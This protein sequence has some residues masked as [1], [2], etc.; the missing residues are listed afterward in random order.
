MPPTDFKGLIYLFIDLINTAL[1]V[2]SGMALLLFIWGLVKFLTKA[3]DVKSHEDGKALMKWGIIA[4]FVMVSFMGI[5]KFA[6]GDFGF[7]G[8]LPTGPRLPQ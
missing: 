8:F 1:P 3:G 2:L 7:T 5:I 6:Y 4:L